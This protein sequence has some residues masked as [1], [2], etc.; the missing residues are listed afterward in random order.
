MTDTSQIQ[1]VNALRKAVSRTSLLAEGNDPELDHAVRQIRLQISKGADATAI[2]AILD[3]VEPLLLKVDEARLTRA[4]H[5]RETLHDLIDILD[6]HG[7]QVPQSQKNAFE[8]AIRSHWQSVPHWPSLLKEYLA[9]I[10]A[11]LAHNAQVETKKAPL[12]AR[13]FKRAQPA[14]TKLNNQEVLQQVRHTLIGLLSNLALPSDYDE[15]ISEL[16]NTLAQNKNFND[17]PKILD[18][19]IA[20]IMIA[21]GNTQ[22]GLTSYLNE[23]NK[24]L[25]SINDSIVKSYRSQKS[26][27][28]SR[29]GL[30]TSMQKQVQEAANAVQQADDLDSLKALINERM[31][32]ISDT[33]AQYRKQMLAQ[34]KMSTQ[35]ISL[36]KSKVTRMEKDTSSLRTSLQEKLAQAMTDALTDLPNRAAYQDTILPLCSNSLANGSPLSLAICDID[37]FKQ[38]ND[39]WGHLAGDKV[40][41]LVPRQIRNVL[42]ASDLLFRYGG[43]EFVIVF[44]GTPLSDAQ[45]R[46][47]A[48]RKEVEK[49]P[50]NVNGEPVSITVSIGLAELTQENYET[51]FSRADKQLYSA[52]EAGRNKVMVDNPET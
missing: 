23:L 18:E 24:Q 4:K 10:E 16:K 22:E 38:V 45:Q 40:L 9:L 48:I 44:P 47:E 7:Q 29:E 5:F 50:F 13:L 3:N 42:A 2:Q 32:N 17:F 8:S 41:R 46:A 1:L 12:I 39:T 37:F 6:H 27:S 15:Q 26:L 21:I 28:E 36:L 30:N 34:E 33:M 35:S 49:A 43:E 11:S 25:A 51:F 31:A 52:K 14:K 20:L 19:L